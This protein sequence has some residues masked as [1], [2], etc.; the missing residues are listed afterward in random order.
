MD[1]L[2]KIADDITRH[3]HEA[4]FFLSHTFLPAQRIEFGIVRI[5]VVEGYIASWKVT[6]SAEA[7]D[8]MLE[9]ILK[10]LTEHNPLLRS[11]LDMAFQ[12]LALFPDIVF[13]P[14]V[15]AIPDELGA[16]ELIIDTEKKHIGGSVSVDNHG[17]EYLGPFQGVMSLRALDLTGHHE[18][19]QLTVAGTA[20][21][22]D[23]LY[24]ELNVDWLLGTNG[25]RIQANLEHTAADLGG[26]LDQLNAHIQSNR[27]RLTAMYPLQRTVNRSTF[28]HLSLDAYR[29]RT[30][31]YGENRLKDRLYSVVAGV[32]AAF[33]PSTATTHSVGVSF[34]KGL[35]VGDSGLVDTQLGPGVGRPDFLKL[36]TYY[37]YFLS[38]GRH[39]GLTT[40]LDGQYA[41]SAL[42]NL[43]LYSIGGREY[44]RAYDPAE[45]TGD[46]GLVGSLEI[47]YRFP[48]TP[49][50]L[51]IDPYV[52]YDLGKVWQFDAQSAAGDSSLASC[53]VGVRA[54]T[55]SLSTFVEVD[56][57]L[58]RPV[59]SKGTDGKHARVFG[60]I[61][62]QF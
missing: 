50:H 45:I 62:Y 60:G 12:R 37:S 48:I 42:P 22:G 8:P 39:W 38:I 16:Y 18:A 14:Y 40:Q 59:A 61:A 35:D 33:Q 53:G 30:D 1:D 56:R 9:A 7:D 20:D 11:T 36:N 23:L 29:S 32:R 31:L 47:S 58:T 34:T 55:A 25:A 2:R 3:Y 13:H 52:F 54:G 27:L 5:R 15:R 44:G 41:F 21:T 28:L 24:G 43:E 4:G 17:S 19:Y 10:P 57:P 46:S 26:S 49:A 51:H 6:G